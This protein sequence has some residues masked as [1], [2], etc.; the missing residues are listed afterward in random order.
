MLRQK[1]SVLE[2]KRAHS[3]PLPSGCA[4]YTSSSFFKSQSPNSKPS[5]KRWDHRFS[6]DTQQLNASVLKAAARTENPAKIITLATGRPA[7][8]FYPWASMTLTGKESSCGKDE[9]MA[10]MSCSAGESA[11]DLSVALNYGYA[12]GSPQALRFVTEHVE[13][14][15]EPPYHDWECSLTCGTSSAIEIALRMFCNRSDWV[16]VEEFTYSGTIDAIKAQGLNILGVKMDE[17]GLS[18][19]DLDL[20]L[21]TW[22]TSTGKR[23]FVL[24]TIPSGQ[25]P[26]GTTQDT[27]RKRAIYEVA[28]KHDLYII[29]DDP[30]YFLQLGDSSLQD[31]FSRTSIDEYFRDL[32]ASYLSLDV[33]GRVMR[34]D[35]TSKILAP[36]LRCGWMTASSQVVDK[37]LAHTETST[38]SASG[39]SQVMLY[40]LLDET[41]GHRGFLEWLLHLSHQYRHRLNLLLDA[42][43][44]YLPPEVCSWTIPTQGMIFAQSK[45]K[46]VLV[47]KGSWFGANRPRGRH[48]SFRMTFAAAPQH[49]L[50]EAVRKFG[51][52]VR[53]EFGVC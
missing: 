33:S 18:P 38:V 36:G 26:T 21:S 19:E 28:E 6:L 27:E 35:T 43:Q 49:A 1:I 51:E 46:G 25:N 45:R 15:H 30:Y 53:E 32:P 52:A 16:L 20:K 22:N 12:A 24:Y 48:V 3:Q 2:E 34:L 9:K 17:C 50:D 47:S 10:D 13:L 40:K 5:A 7:A 44:R 8:E 29:E 31:G 23:P 37:F 41:W 4:P 14:I 11:Y 42:C 39:P